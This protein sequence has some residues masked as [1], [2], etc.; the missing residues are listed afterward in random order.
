VDLLTELA[1]R[2]YIRGQ[3][4][5]G[6]A[7]D[8]GINP[9]TVSRHLK[10]ARQDGIVHVEIRLPSVEL[11]DLG[12]ELASDFDV[13]RAIVLPGASEDTLH[14]GGAEHVG[15]LLRTGMRVGISWGQTLAGVVRYLQPRS[16]SDLSISQLTGGLSDA[17]PGYQCHELVRRMA[18]LYPGSRVKY[19]HAPAIV[20]TAEIHSAITSDKSVR[21]AL[22]S[23]SKSELA[24]VGIGSMGLDATLMRVGHLAARD[25][26]RLRR[27]GAVGTLN[28]RFFD[29]DGKPIRLLEDRTVALSW[30]QLS[31]I[32]TVVAVAGG[33]QKVAAIAGAIR[34]GSLD[35][36]VTDES[37]ARALLKLNRAQ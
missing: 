23:A 5:S 27:A 25:Q 19:L 15:S 10:R 32:P 21:S 37:T 12:R 34:T 4:Q 8:L 33:K 26:D 9:S 20:D 13:R 14:A 1:T 28:G 2:F 11:V 6:I 16:V 24:L 29:A 7:R 17:E 3:S 35:V 36:L 22:H 30:E 18:Q 31:A